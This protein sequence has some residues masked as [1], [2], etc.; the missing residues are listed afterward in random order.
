MCSG[1][2]EAAPLGGLPGPL[3]PRWSP[4]R[5]YVYIYIYTHV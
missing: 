4:K 2:L 3:P 1:L 5:V